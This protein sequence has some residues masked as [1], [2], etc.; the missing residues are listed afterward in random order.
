MVLGMIIGAE[1]IFHHGKTAGMRTYAMV[2]MG[3]AL[4]VIVSE[5]LGQKYSGIG[6]FNMAQIAS[7]IV[8]GVGFLGAGMIM[9]KESQVVGL[10]TAGGL[11]VSAGIGTAAGFGFFNLAI[12]ATI[13]TF[14][15]FTILFLV[16]EKF[17]KISDVINHDKQV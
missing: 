7:N 8:V 14:F 5:L 12:I 16:E 3:S 6:G 2:S 9:I 13:L 10:T 15:I 11:W 1:R 17:R 4:F